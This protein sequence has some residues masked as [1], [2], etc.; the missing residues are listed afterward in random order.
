[1]PRQ[2]DDL[3]QRLARIESVYQA[4][5]GLWSDLCDEEERALLELYGVGP[6]APPGPPPPGLDALERRRNEALMALYGL[7]LPRP[8]QVTLALFGAD[9]W[10]LAELG[11]AYATLV[12][13][14]GAEVGLWRFTSEPGERGGGK[15]VVGKAVPRGAKGSVAGL[16]NGAAAGALGIAF[17]VRHPAALVRFSDEAGVHELI[18][19]DARTSKLAILVHCSDEV[20]RKY[21]PP[22]N[23]M[24]RSMTKNQPIRRIH[25]PGQGSFEDKVLDRSIRAGYW[26]RLHLALAE[27][28]DEACL[29]LVREAVFT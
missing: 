9:E 25:F 11:G 22:P 3:R 5:D 29:K 28:I 7:R 10:A 13:G 16:V 17:E 15:K 21:R 26:S 18:S 14:I 24:R 20:G 4:V 19:G 23:V 1:M 27:A 6:E 8:D 12:E 2:Y